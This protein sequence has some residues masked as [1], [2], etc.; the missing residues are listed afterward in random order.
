MGQRFWLLPLASWFS[1]WFHESDFF[2]ILCRIL[3]FFWT[4]HVVNRKRLQNDNSNKWT[5]RHMLNRRP[6][7]GRWL[8][9]LLSLPHFYQTKK[10]LLHLDGGLLDF[11]NFTNA[12]SAV[13]LIRFPS[14]TDSS[15]IFVHS[16]TANHH[17]YHYWS[18]HVQFFIFILF[19]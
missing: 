2:F 6:P 7:P 12:T 8:T 3:S 10:D 5:T 13:W 11:E 1:P 19:Y 14:K 15:I 4:N 16:E 17:K 9:H 18:I